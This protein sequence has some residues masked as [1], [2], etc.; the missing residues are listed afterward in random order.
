[1]R[2]ITPMFEE[3]QS[4]TRKHMNRFSLLL[5]DI[6]FPFFPPLPPPWI[7]NFSQYQ[8]PF[9]ITFSILKTIIIKKMYFFIIFNLFLCFS[10][11]IDLPHFL[12]PWPC[13]HFQRRLW[14]SC[15]KN[16]V[17]SLKLFVGMFPVDGSQTL[18]LFC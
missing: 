13:L 9:I 16:H 6:V 11:Y 5:E 18:L 12:S 4:V 10:F 8:Q 15:C 2:R 1:M 17:C 14:I 7:S 3:Y